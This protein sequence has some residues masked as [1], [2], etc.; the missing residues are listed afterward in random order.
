VTKVALCQQHDCSTITLHTRCMAH[1]QHQG[2]GQQLANN[3]VDHR[4]AVHPRAAVMNHR[5]NERK[6]A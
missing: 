5:S 4:Y 2:H 1:R 3:T 6:Y